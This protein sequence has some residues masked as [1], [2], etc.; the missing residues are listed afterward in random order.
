M[1]RN[2]AKRRHPRRR[3]GPETMTHR[4]FKIGCQLVSHCEYRSL[5]D[6]KSG[7]T[8]TLR[9][10]RRVQSNSEKFRKILG[11]EYYRRHNQFPPKACI[12]RAL[13]WLNTTRFKPQSTLA[14]PE[15]SPQRGWALE[16]SEG[17][18]IVTFEEQENG[19][20]RR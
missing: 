18:E 17:K 8:I 13:G 5:A 14:A 16:I 6:W 2:P 1:S 4:I 9:D 11:F 7:H 12:T 20:L 3:P 15:P 19:G 10:G